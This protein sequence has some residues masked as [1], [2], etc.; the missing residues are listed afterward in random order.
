MQASSFCLQVKSTWRQLGSRKKSSFYS[1]EQTLSNLLSY[2]LKTGKLIQKK[3]IIQILIT[4]VE[5]EVRFCT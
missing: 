5:A 3:T 4:Q 1:T 2:L